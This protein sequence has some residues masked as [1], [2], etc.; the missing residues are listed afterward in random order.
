MTTGSYD[1]GGG[2]PSTSGR[3]AK[4]FTGLD[5]K[6]EVVNGRRR[7]KWNSFTLRYFQQTSQQ[8]QLM[9]IVGGTGSGIPEWPATAE[10]QLQSKLVAKVK[11]H[12]FNLAVSAAEG[13]Q[14]VELAV[15][16][17]RKMAV[18]LTMM[19]RGRFGD[20]LRQLGA[21]KKK[22]TKDLTSLRLSSGD[23]SQA[24]LEARYG[25]QPLLSDVY[26][27]TSAYAALTRFRKNV[28]VTSHRYVNPKTDW[29]ASPSSY[30]YLGSRVTTTFLK[31]EMSEDIQGYR[32]LG[33]VDPLSVLWEITPFSFVFDWFLPIGSYLE[34]LNVVPF[35]QGRFLTTR[36]C[37]YVARFSGDLS[38]SHAY[39]PTTRGEYGK[40]VDRLTAVSG[41]STQRPQF[42]Q[43]PNA[44]KPIRIF[45]AVAL[46][47]QIV[48]KALR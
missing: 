11:G 23:L 29:S 3:R 33:L 48:S 28:I 20:A 25:W 34:N 32:S 42:V 22:G 18:A 21:K 9:N 47:H 39:T 17:I 27:A 15:N 40:G 19:R 4:S 13:K 43:L 46:A 45:N 8:G 12:Q 14:V 10:F 31:Y 7:L 6:Y 38:P 35:L 44:M 36:V 37:E 24:W 41:L 2:Y 16:T 5:G 1:S 30:S 26:E